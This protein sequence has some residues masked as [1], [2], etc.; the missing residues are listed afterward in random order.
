MSRNYLIVHLIVHLIVRTIIHVTSPRKQARKY[1][2][3]YETGSAQAQAWSG[4]RPPGP[5]PAQARACARL[6]LLREVPPRG[7]L[8]RPSIRQSAPAFKN[9]PTSTHTHTRTQTHAFLQ[10]FVLAL[11][12]RRPAPPTHTAIDTSWARQWMRTVVLTLPGR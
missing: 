4:L 1:Q 3:Q 7:C 10:R 12:L 5:V 11:R 6:G 8:R 2:A 9:Q